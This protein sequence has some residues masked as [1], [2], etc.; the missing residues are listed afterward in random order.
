MLQKHKV[1]GLVLLATLIGESFASAANPW[2]KLRRPLHIPRLAAGAR[3]PVSTVT[4]PSQDYGPALGRGPAYPLYPWRAGTLSFFYPVR[5]SHEW[6]PSA[7][8]GEKVL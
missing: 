4:H 7:W 3:C 6:Y 1:L 8:S 2:Q 5:P